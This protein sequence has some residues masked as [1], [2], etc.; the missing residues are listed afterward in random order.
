[1]RANVVG[2]VL[3]GWQLEAHLQARMIQGAAA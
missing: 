1:V 3:P 2:G